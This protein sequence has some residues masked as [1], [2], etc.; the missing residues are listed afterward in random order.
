V[1]TLQKRQKKISLPSAEL[2]R[3]KKLAEKDGFG[4][5]VTGWVR[6]LIRKQCTV[7][8]VISVEA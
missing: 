3:A 7:S 1:L 6:W 5:N 2:E 4:S 8:D